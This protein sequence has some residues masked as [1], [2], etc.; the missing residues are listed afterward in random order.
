VFLL[1]CDLTSNLRNLLVKVTQGADFHF[2]LALTQ[3]SVEGATLRLIISLFVFAA[4]AFGSISN[5][6]QNGDFETG[7][8]MNW[9][10]DAGANNPWAIDT[11][12]PH[13][14]S[15]DVCNG[16]IDD[17]CTIGNPIGQLDSLSQNLSTIA[18]HTY[19]LTFFY[20]P[21]EPGDETDASVLLVDWAGT[22]VLGL[23]LQGT[24]T[25]RGE[26]LPL[27]SP[28]T[29]LPGYNQYTVTGI[30]ATSTS[31][32]L[33]FIGRQ[34]FSF[35]FLDDIVV[36]DNASAV[37]EPSSYLLAAGGLLAFGMTRLRARRS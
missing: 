28:V 31:T 24:G 7:N 32:N 27:V 30:T 34:D 8:L 29:P 11:S 26:Q 36:T 37:P 4:A 9:T 1:S 6:V 17:V 19:T 10:I 14:G 16:C 20:D 33:N 22:E 23:F 18:G 12:D 21:G 5:L 25:P 13:N 2:R 15:F 3:E 35:S